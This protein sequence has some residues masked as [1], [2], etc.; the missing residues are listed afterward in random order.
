MPSL[1]E[2]LARSQAAGQMISPPSAPTEEPERAPE[3]EA[4]IEAAPA[5]LDSALAWVDSALEGLDP[6]TAEEV[7]VHLNAIREIVANEPGPA[8]GQPPAGGPEI[9]ASAVPLGSQ[10][11]ELPKTGV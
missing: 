3:E 8:N 6:K 7:R 1:K 5:D 11:E 10:K 4:P 9:P 2:L